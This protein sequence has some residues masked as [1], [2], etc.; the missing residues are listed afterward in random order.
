LVNV[1][2]Y[3]GKP[4][5]NEKKE[6][7]VGMK[8]VVKLVEPYFNTKRCVTADNFFSSIP[9]CNYLWEK[10]L[11]FIGTLKQNKLEIPLNFLKET[12]KTAG[13]FLRSVGSSL[14]AF[15]EY[16]TLVSYVPKAKKSVI[17]LSTHHH[18][19]AIDELTGKPKIIMDYN[20][21]K[22]KII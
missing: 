20:S 12:K 7:Q 1:D 9:L 4:Q 2:I 5:E 6:T 14:F 16:L 11:Q 17:L 8:T 19:S 22:G 13:I 10:S 3:L 18:D 21:Y 15:K